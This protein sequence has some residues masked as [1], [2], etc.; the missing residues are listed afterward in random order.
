MERDLEAGSPT[1]FSDSLGGF[2]DMAS[3]AAD[4]HGAPPA[5]QRRHRDL[6]PLPVPAGDERSFVAADLSRTTK[7][8]LHR[9]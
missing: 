1:A 4:V 6:F 8:R 7:R 5:R 2:A 9:T 3:R